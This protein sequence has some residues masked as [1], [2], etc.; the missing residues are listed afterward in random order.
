[1][2]NCLTDLDFFESHLKNK[3]FIFFIKNVNIYY[4]IELNAD[5]NTKVILKKF[6]I[7][8]SEEEKIIINNIINL[9][10]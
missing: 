3:Q 4:C 9:I 10:F 6:N 7:T 5:L 8:P 1:M 2:N